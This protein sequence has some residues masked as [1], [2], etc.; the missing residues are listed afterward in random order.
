MNQIT[1]ALAKVDSSAKVA[2]S[3]LNDLNRS[4]IENNDSNA[5]L[6]SLF[7]FLKIDLFLIVIRLIL[8]YYIIFDRML[9]FSVIILNCFFSYFICF[10][11]LL[12]FVC[13]LL[14]L[15]TKYTFAS[16]QLETLWNDIDSDR[17]S[18]IAPVPVKPFMGAFTSKSI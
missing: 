2:Y 3:T 8:H 6:V 14:L 7:F 12:R 1:E 11:S 10:L 17:F 9:C 5:I 13:L 4:L 16:K 15:Q 18:L